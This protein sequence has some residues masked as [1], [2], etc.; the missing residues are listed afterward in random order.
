MAGDAASLRDARRMV[1]DTLAG[2]APDD[3][4]LAVLLAGEVV[5]NAVV[6]GGG[7]F[8]LEVESGAG[9][10]RVEVT[11]ASSAAPRVLRPSG[12]REHGRG[13]SIVDHLASSWGT[14][15]LGTH[16]VVWFE[17]PLRV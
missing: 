17:M 7:W 13:M 12:T 16:K 2:A 8:L 10:I 6:H 15:H 9:R 14:E 3:V 1:A 5:T 11:D 4:D